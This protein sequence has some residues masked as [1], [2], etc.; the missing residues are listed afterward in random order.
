MKAS[1]TQSRIVRFGVFEVDLQERNLRRSGLRQ[2]LGPQPFQVL[3]ALL[4]RPG[5][6]V[7]RD[8]LRDRL[9]PDK[10]FV[11]HELA[12]K[13]CVNRIREVLGDSAENPRFVE[14][15]PRR[16][17]RF[18]AP[19]QAAD[20]TS[21]SRDSLAETTPP[22]AS[23]R[24][25]EGRWTIIVAVTVIVAASVPVSWWSGRPS[26]LAVE[27]VR[28]LTDDRLS[29]S[30]IDLETDGNRVYFNEGSP[31]NHRIMEVSVSGG[32]TAQIVAELVNPMLAGLQADGSALV[33]LAGKADDMNYPLWSI[34]LPAG[35]P[36][37][38]GGT[39]VGYADVFRDG[40]LLYIQGSGQAG[41]PSSLYVAERDGSK[42]RKV[43]EMSQRTIV[44]PHAS[45]DGRKINFGSVG[46]DGSEAI[47][48]V[49]ADGAGLH[50]VVRGGQGE[51]PPH[52]CCAKWTS[53]GQYLVFQSQPTGG[54]WDL[55]VLPEHR[56][57]FN[58]QTRKPFR[59]TN[60]PLSYDRIA[61]G[62]E[63]KT[64]FAVGSQRRSELVRYDAGLRQ[65]VPYLGGISALS[66]TFSQDGEWVAYLSYPDLTL[67]RS[68]A[69][70]R[71]RLQLT[72]SPMVVRYPRLSPDGSKIFFN[73]PN[74]DG[75]VIA[76]AGGEPHKITTHAYAS[77]WSPDGNRL[78]YTS[79][80][81]PKNSSEADT[82][83]LHTLDLRNGTTTVV[84][85]SRGKFGAFF[86]DQDTI[87]A[88]TENTTKFL[89]YDFKAQKWSNLW[90]GN[91]LEWYLSPD[92]S[93]LY[94]IIGEEPTAMRIRLSDH[95]IETVASLKN[96][97]LITDFN[98]L[99]LSV[100]PDGSPLFARDI[101]T[102]E[103][104]ALSLK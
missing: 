61:P 30:G 83:E 81:A 88:A 65:F 92:R 22:T 68:H 19:V 34:P 84:T 29:K 102:Q 49:G 72:Y 26:L 73:T 93:Y 20:V 9:W 52:V 41:G 17:Y 60:G 70:G 86:V 15:V 43:A 82:L 3:E 42:A 59:L 57:A 4:Q 18:I 63:G 13:K 75:F 39:K 28:Q 46:G 45:P 24:R 64:I 33:A 76:S 97:R 56:G 95:K 74:G 1:S 53:D 91:I 69:D 27:G 11:D 62:R 32:Q 14:T 7:T 6:I 2:K 101:G 79:P 51:L 99:K 12:L 66:P 25:F 8:E 31:G 47:Y 36:R 98:T 100:A 23:H 96:L 89:L 94:C 5:E 58:Y 78:I 40:H 21:S 104:Y 10:T 71:E 85:D 55:W 87:V 50:E 37:R 38:L 67:W 103:I 48:E 35:E 44:H 54:R 90:S 77:A 80:A 16:G